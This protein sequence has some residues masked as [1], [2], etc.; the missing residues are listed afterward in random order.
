M[1]D[2]AHRLV[3]Y[4][5]V[6]P[7]RLVRDLEWKLLGE[8]ART[9]ATDPVR[10]RFSLACGCGDARLRVVGVPAV[11][12]AARGGRFLQ[13][14]LRGFREVRAVPAGGPIFQPPVAMLCSR[15]GRESELLPGSAVQSGSRAGPPVREALRC[16]ACGVSAF[17]LAASFGFFVA[18]LDLDRLVGLEERYDELAIE[19]RCTGCRLALPVA[20]LGLRSERDAR[21]A[22]LSPDRAPDT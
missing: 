2:L 12:A 8:D 16:R 22:R 6:H 21:L 13:S 5:S 15:C 4:L 14:V 20:H 17:E 3:G 10:V 1:E 19:A 18:G 11:V 9:E 7:P